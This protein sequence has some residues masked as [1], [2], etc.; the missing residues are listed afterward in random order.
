MSR[1]AALDQMTLRLAGIFE[2]TLH[3]G[4]ESLGIFVG[5][6]TPRFNVIDPFLDQHAKGCFL[7]L[8]QKGEAGCDDRIS[9]LVKARIHLFLDKFSVLLA[10][11]NVPHAGLRS[12]KEWEC[13]EQ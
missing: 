7:L 1:R 2:H 8:S 5:V 9:A 4:Q 11:L 12:V 6:N 3:V 13:L 10:Q